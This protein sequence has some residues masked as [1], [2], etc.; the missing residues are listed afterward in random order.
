M[1]FDIA[2]VNGEKIDAFIGCI[3][4]PCKMVDS[5]YIYANL[6]SL[7]FL[8]TKLF[9]RDPGKHLLGA[10]DLVAASERFDLREYLI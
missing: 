6:F 3:V 9:F 10:E 5:Q 7:Y 8:H 2:S 4:K 1:L